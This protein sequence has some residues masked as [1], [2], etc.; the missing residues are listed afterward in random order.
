MEGT[1]LMNASFWGREDVVEFL[2]QNGAAAK[3]NKLRDWVRL[4]N[5][6]LTVDPID[7]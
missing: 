1:A 6:G 5:Y 2:L 7:Y 3:I 4:R